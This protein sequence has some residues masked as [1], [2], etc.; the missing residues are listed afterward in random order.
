MKFGFFLWS[1]CAMAMLAIGAVNMV[2]HFLVGVSL[3]LGGMVVAAL[4][5]VKK[6]I[7]RK[8]QRV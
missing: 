3:V 4:G 5:F 6:A 1:L 2:N 8:S 7:W